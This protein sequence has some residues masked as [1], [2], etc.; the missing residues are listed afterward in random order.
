MRILFIG[1]SYTL[2]NGG[3]PALLRTLAKANGIDVHAEACAT[4]GKS[5]EWHWNEGTSRQA[6][7]A[8]NWD[9]VVLQDFSLQAIDKPKLLDEYVK[10]FD[11]H[12]VAAGASTMLYTTWARQDQPETQR[13]ITSA[14]AAAAATNA[15]IVPVG[16]AWE[17]S[18][19]NRANV[20][21]HMPDRSHPTPAGSYLAACAF[22]ITLFD[23]PLKPLPATLR[24]DDGKVLIELAQ[25]DALFLQHVAKIAVRDDVAPATSLSTVAT[26][27]TGTTTAPTSAPADGP[28][29]VVFVCDAT[30]TMIGSKFK[31]LKT[32]VIAAIDGLQPR[33]QFNIIFFRGGDSF[34]ERT[35][36]MSSQLIS[37]TAAARED[38]K[39]FIQDFKVIGSG[40]DPIFAFRKAMQFHPSEMVILSDGQFNNIADYD[41]AMRELNTL[42]RAKRTRIS[43]VDLLSEDERARKMLK[44]IAHEHG[45]DYRSVSE[46]NE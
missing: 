36:L 8:G 40:T 28:R 9:V 26:Q 21:L 16:P 29:R 31:L 38:A 30:G 44:A 5:L 19:K 6:I 33:D 20:A 4:D 24:D 14:Y 18:L 42:N 1:N 43:T 46:K 23:V 15:T 27:P 45:G 32:E 12:I 37:A 41:R 13:A 2:R 34:F 35:K 17:T 39:N 3:Q 7:D 11:E 10:K 22:Y 25:A